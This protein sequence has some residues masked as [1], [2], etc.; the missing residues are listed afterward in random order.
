[1][2]VRPDHHSRG[3]GALTAALLLLAA[4][5]PSVSI[6]DKYFGG[7]GVGLLLLIGVVVALC[8]ARWGGRWLRVLSSG[9]ADVLAMLAL[10]L[11]LAVVLFVYPRVNVH[12]P[13]HGSDR[14]DALLDATSALLHGH[15]PY[16]Q[17]TYLGNP[18]TPMP[19]ALILAIP[20]VLLGNVGLANVFWCGALFLVLRWLLHDSRPAL[21]VLAIALLSPE[22]MHE[23]ATGGDMF[24]NGVYVGIFL[25]LVAQAAR[26]S[27]KSWLRKAG[28]AALLGVGLSSRPTYLFALP[29]LFQ[30]L[31]IRTGV[32]AAAGW[33][34]LSVVVLLGITA[35]FYF[36]APT[37]FAPLH[38][39]SKL[40]SMLSTMR[41]PSL[42]VTSVSAA[43]AL[44]C[45]GLPLTKRSA[46]LA[47]AGFVVA[48]P[49]YV[50][51]IAWLIGAARPA[52]SEYFATGLSATG[53]YLMALGFALGERE[54]GGAEGS[55]AACA[56]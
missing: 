23:I 28:A 32:R 17:P 39:S 6:V 11:V 10:L 26:S 30:Y 51:V 36:A 19:G 52:A 20:F 27:E 3:D 22:V 54:I 25:L 12:T 7:W 48:F 5:E 4:V 53:L 15:Y 33:T 49:T 55:N 18:I 1:L 13:M 31:R 42:V 50:V 43:L 46:M 21:V 35:P 29:A 41:H 24:A 8:L 34:A 56:P 16:G 14:D 2:N 47:A 40:T 9:Q 37:E 44:V 38:L 45:I